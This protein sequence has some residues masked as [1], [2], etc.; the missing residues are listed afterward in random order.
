MQSMLLPNLNQP[1]WRREIMTGPVANVD[2][3]SASRITM[4]SAVERRDWWDESVDFDMRSFWKVE[5]QG[6]DE[7]DGRKDPDPLANYPKEK[8]IR[9]P[10]GSFQ[11]ELPW[12]KDRKQLR[13]NMEMSSG[14]LQSLLNRL[15]RTPDLMEQYHQQIME[16]VQAGYVEE[17]DMSYNGPQ[18]YLPHHPVVRPEKMTTKVRP[19]FDGS[20]KTK[21]SPSINE[22]LYT[23]PNITPEL[24]SV[25]LRFRI[26]KVAWIADIK[27][28]FHQVKLAPKDS[29][30]IR[31]LWVR[32][33]SDP[34]SPLVHYTWRVL[35]FGLVCSPYILRACINVLLDC[36]A[37][38]YPETVQLIRDQLYVDDGLGGAS[39][40]DLAES[41]MKEIN[42]IFKSAGMSMRKWMSN[43]PSLR[44][45]FADASADDSDGILSECLSGGDSP[46]VLG[47]VWDPVE[48]VFQFNP[49]KIIEAAAA[50]R[51]T[52]TKRQVAQIQSRI[53]D[54]LGFL[55]PVTVISK[56]MFQKIWAAKVDWDQPVTPEIERD[57]KEFIGGLKN[58]SAL[59]IP[60][61]AVA[62]AGSA[63]SAELHVFCD[64]STK[65]YGK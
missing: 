34:N 42:L 38:V 24:L 14:R 54:P 30:V 3:M 19:V 63:A 50:I 62:E 4:L 7:G 16:N 58:L 37:D 39:S 57:W 29:Q 6:T 23:G 22:M 20:A 49:Q 55:A 44:S 21:F 12:M 46:K 56:I 32:D 18:T 36:Y 15:R 1:D 2:C 25:L 10:D 41:T 11:A 9:L 33:P 60:R 40:V 35:P 26:P 27:K 48:D 31:F 28:A 53:F 17:A 59:K 13:S 43:D 65:A 45:K 8:I 5:G 52:P 61:R 47:L 51:G 64:A